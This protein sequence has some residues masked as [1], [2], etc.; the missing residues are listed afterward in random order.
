[1][2]KGIGVAGIGAEISTGFIL[3][4][5]GNNHEAMRIRFEHFEDTGNERLRIKGYFRQQDDVRRV[6]I[7][8]IFAT[9][10]NRGSSEPASV[11]AHNFEDGNEIVLSHR[12]IVQ[13][14][15]AHG[16]GEVLS[17]RTITWAVVG[18]G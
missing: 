14:H 17:D 12:R 13:G 6:G 2:A 18:N 5:F 9:S 1:M 8:T 4:T 16:G 10:Q 7:L 3:Y 11:A 15:F